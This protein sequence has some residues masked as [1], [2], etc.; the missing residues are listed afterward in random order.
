MNL[1]KIFLSQCIID[2]LLP[3]EIKLELEPSI[4]NHNEAF[5]TNWYEK[6]NGFFTERHCR[7]L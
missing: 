6:L 3:N 2:K 7:V 5:V 4:D 1:V